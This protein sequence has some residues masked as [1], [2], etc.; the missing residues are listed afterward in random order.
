MIQVERLTKR[1]GERTAVQDIGF[2]ISKGEVIGFLGPNGAGKTTTL[3]M[4]TGY[5]APDEGQITIDG[6][7]VVAEPIQARKRI[8]YMP[9]SVPLYLELRVEEYL[10]YRAK[11]KGVGSGQLK[12]RISNAM[13][14][15]QISDVRNRIIGQLSRGYRSRVG[16]AD[17]LVAQPPILILDEP[18]A[19]LDPNQIRQVRNLIRDMAGKITVLLSTHILPEVEYTCSRVL[20]IH[21]G[22][23]VGEGTPGDLRIAGQASQQ[24]TVEGRGER[25]RFTA[26]LERVKGVRKITD[27]SVLQPDPVMPLVRIRL[28]A[29]PEPEVSEAVF[30]AVAEAG[31]TL[32][33]L[34]RDRTSLED[35]FASL[36]TEEATHAENETEPTAPAN[37]QGGQP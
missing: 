2:N 1:Y 11:L 3:R 7:D 12:A 31:L 28:E 10:R 14:M 9:E 32:R 21:E 4:L 27:A 34:R 26:V 30:A 35:V 18:T 23:L 24:I 8:G 37:E 6:V 33:E 29:E 16:L 36:T 19:G 17:A 20:I 5:L 25:E 22:R 15:A 13:E